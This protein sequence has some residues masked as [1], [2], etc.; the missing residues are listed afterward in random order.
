MMLAEDPKT[1][2]ARHPA[3]ML[4]ML[5]ALIGL[6]S[7][8]GP[9]LYEECSSVDDDECSSFWDFEER[10]CAVIDA[11]ANWLMCQP[12]AGC[13]SEGQSCAEDAICR[14]VGDGGAWHCL[15]SCATA[16]DCQVGFYC[17]SIREDE[18]VCMHQE[19]GL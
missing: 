13:S 10:H 7:C 8:G 2:P 5:A 14:Q 11:A 18:G 19:S 17:L 3:F 4:F 6:I 16:A 15:A 9:K 1:P 12:L